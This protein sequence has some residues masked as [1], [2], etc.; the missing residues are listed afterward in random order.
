MDYIVGTLK[1][2]G[3]SASLIF[4]DA[5]ISLEFDTAEVKDENGNVDRKSVV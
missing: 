1:A 4:Q 3:I 5:N 2:E